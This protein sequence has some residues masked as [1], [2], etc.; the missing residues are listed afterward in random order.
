MFSTMVVQRCGPKSPYLNIRPRTK[1]NEKD[2]DGDLV[3]DL[4][5]IF[6]IS[7]YAPMT[8]AELKSVVALTPN[9]RS[10]NLFE[11]LTDLTCVSDLDFLNGDKDGNGGMNRNRGTRGI[12][13]KDLYLSYKYG[14][15]EKPMLYILAMPHIKYLGICK[16]VLKLDD[17][18]WL[19]AHVKERRWP[20]K[21]FS[22]YYEDLI[23]DKKNKNFDRIIKTVCRTYDND[24]E[25]LF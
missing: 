5:E 12:R 23:K 24:L 10:L 8:C 20:F 4:E 13:I 7:V 15:F 21:A 2:A 1:M 22:C 3:S 25:D 9:L 16:Y 6:D 11:G 18:K 17:I 19:A 14:S